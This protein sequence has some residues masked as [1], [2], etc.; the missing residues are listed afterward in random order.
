[1]SLLRGTLLNSPPRSNFSE[2]CTF[3]R[4]PFTYGVIEDVTTLSRNCCEMALARCEL[5]LLF[6]ALALMTRLAGTPSHN[7]LLTVLFALAPMTRFM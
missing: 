1:M 2:L 7:M 4:I 3:R 5:S 6:H